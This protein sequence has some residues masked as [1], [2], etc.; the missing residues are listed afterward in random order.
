[1]SE[2]TEVSREE[3]PQRVVPFSPP[4]ITKAEI[5][6]VVDTLQSG[7]ITTGPKTK[8]LEARLADFTKAARVACLSSATSALEC[9]LR[10]L[11]IGPG[12][13][14]ITSAYTYTASCSPICHIGAT[15]VLADTAPDSY[16]M[17]YDSL[18]AL[19]TPRTR[20]IIPVDIA[21][22]LCDYDRLLAVVEGARNRFK[23]ASRRQDEIG[24]IAIVAD[25]AHALGATRGGRHAGEIADLTT[26][27]FHA[28][29]NFTTAEGGA[30]AWRQRPCSTTRRSTKT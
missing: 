1:M 19:I 23:P 22:R 24:R 6:E 14:V 5:D 27:S 13:E 20:A 2:A 21:G 11:G 28:V 12:D 26:F 30:L 8:L 25:G 29:K 15:P 18:D 9:A 10:A 3:K 16:E 4:D 7:W 17:D